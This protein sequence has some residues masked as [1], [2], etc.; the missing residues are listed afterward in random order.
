MHRLRD[1]C[2]SF[3]I[4]KDFLFCLFFSLY[5]SLLFQLFEYV[6]FQFDQLWLPFTCLFFFLGCG[7]SELEL[8]E[9]SLRKGRRAAFVVYHVLLMQ[10]KSVLRRTHLSSS[11]NN[12][13]R[14]LHLGL[15]LNS[16]IW[17]KVVAD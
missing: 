1:N 12:R 10:L 4:L 16:L 3:C 8:R 6:L 7:V 5:K 11:C 14:I 2:G 15:N 9:L 17:N 13:S